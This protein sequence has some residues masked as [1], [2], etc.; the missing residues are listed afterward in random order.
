ML[1]LRQRANRLDELVIDGSPYEKEGKQF[2]HSQLDTT[3]SKDLLKVLD[4]AFDVCD[5]LHKA[6]YRDRG[7]KHVYFFHKSMAR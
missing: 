2:S 7:P 3:I 6:G 5:T 1:A 4:C